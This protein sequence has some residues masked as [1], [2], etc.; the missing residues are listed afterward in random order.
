MACHAFPGL[1]GPLGAWAD[2]PR[3]LVPYPSAHRICQRMPLHVPSQPHAMT[4]AGAC[5]GHRMPLR[6]WA[7]RG[8]G[9]FATGLQNKGSTFVSMKRRASLTWRHRLAACVMLVAV[10]AMLVHMT[11]PHHHH[12]RY[13]AL[14]CMHMHPER[15][16]GAVPHCPSGGAGCQA[17]DVAD[18][19]AGELMAQVTQRASLRQVLDG[20][21]VPCNFLFP[22]LF[23]QAAWPLC[24]GLLLGGGGRHAWRRSCR[25]FLLGTA[26]GLPSGLRAP[27]CGC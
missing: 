23:L 6:F 3:Q 18:C 14:V 5:V 1:C 20:T 15:V 4:E 24:P 12:A 17:E 26:H 25:A 8:V 22:F 2:F 27:P 11:V 10:L 16:H 7:H 21:S 9:H 19:H 13:V